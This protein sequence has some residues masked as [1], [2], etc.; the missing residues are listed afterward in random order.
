MQMENQGNYNQILKIAQQVAGHKAVLRERTEE[1][2]RRR[3]D[4]N[5]DCDRD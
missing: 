2:R 4:R 3:R 5:I 1:E